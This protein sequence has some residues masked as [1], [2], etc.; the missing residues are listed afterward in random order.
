M[1]PATLGDMRHSTVSDL[2]GSSCN[3]QGDT[4]HDRWLWV[5]GYTQ[6]R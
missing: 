2:L 6:W 5:G 4:R 3:Q 1:G